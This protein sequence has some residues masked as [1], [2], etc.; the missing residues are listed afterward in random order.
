MKDKPEALQPV[1]I[2]GNKFIFSRGDASAFRSILQGESSFVFG[3][4]VVV[5]H[6]QS[7]RTRLARSAHW[8]KF[9]GR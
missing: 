9:R 8:R 7:F 5:A 4:P 2:I 1:L 6:V 3:H